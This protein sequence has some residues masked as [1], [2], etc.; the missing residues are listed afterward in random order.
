MLLER[1]N[2]TC[3]NKQILKVPKDVQTYKNYVKSYN[4][5]LQEVKKKKIIFRIITIK[6]VLLAYKIYDEKFC[7]RQ[8]PL[9]NLSVYLVHSIEQHKE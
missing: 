8:Q 9:S 7:Y 5:L 3:N 6:S 2:Q 1:A 4:E